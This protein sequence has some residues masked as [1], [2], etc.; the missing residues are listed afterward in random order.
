MIVQVLIVGWYQVGQYQVPTEQIQLVDVWCDM[1]YVIID[2][3]TACVEK[4]KERKG[5]EG[6]E[7]TQTM[8]VCDQLSL[9]DCCAR[10]YVFVEPILHV[11]REDY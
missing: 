2:T 3:G 6:K 1:S 7:T 4:K 9:H 11:E 5:R 10:E 8:F